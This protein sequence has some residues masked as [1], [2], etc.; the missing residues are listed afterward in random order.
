MTKLVCPH[1][2]TDRRPAILKAILVSGHRKISTVNLGKEFDV[3][4]QY[5]K[6]GRNWMISD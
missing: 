5:M 1:V 4:K 6:F 2:Q 3:T